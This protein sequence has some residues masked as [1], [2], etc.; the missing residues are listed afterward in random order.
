MHAAVVDS[1]GQPPAY[2][3]F[4]DPVAGA[5]AP[6]RS[7]CS[8]RD[9]PAGPLPGG[10]LALHEHRALPLIPGIDGVGRDAGRALR[11]FLLPDTHLGS[12]AEQTLID[13]RRSAVLPDGVD[14]VA[15]RR[16]D[17][18]GDVLVDRAD[19]GASTLAPR[20][21]RARARRDRQ[22]G[23]HGGADREAPRRLARHRG[24]PGRPQARRAARARRGRAH[25]AAAGRRRGGG[26]RRGGSRARRGAR[27]RLGR[28]RRRRAPGDRPARED[29]DRP[30]PLDRDRLDGRARVAD[31]LRRPAR[32]GPPDRR[33]RPGLGARPRD[34]G[35]PSC[36]AL[37]RPRSPSGAYA[38]S[39]RGA[40]PLRDVTAAWQE[41]TR[42]P[43]RLVAR[44]G[45]SGRPRSGQAEHPVQVGVAEEAARVEAA[46]HR[47]EVVEPRVAGRAGRPRRGCA[48]C[49]SAAGRRS[50]GRPA[51]RSGSTRGARHGGS[52]AP[53][54]RRSGDRRRC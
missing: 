40:V 19:A 53:R 2:R 24:R 8:R 25:R 41:R 21:A 43:P 48:A 35:W 27:L 32:H 28:A 47:Q 29:D 38:T 13:P 44:M 33:Q 5:T 1:F 37:A 12:M 18:P 52:S 50:R 11:Y 39:P 26:P 42:R 9:P 31:P 23:P 3:E 45:I 17:E 16:G 30:A 54:C 10:R 15:D 7:T 4:P 51:P 22:R 14:P 34:F 6:R 46:A 20:R 49:P 36:P